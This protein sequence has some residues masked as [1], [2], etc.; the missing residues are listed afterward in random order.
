MKKFL[1]IVMWGFIIGGLLSGM[2]HAQSSAYTTIKKD[3]TDEL[4]MCLVYYAHKEYHLGVM[5]KEKT[6]TYMMDTC[7]GIHFAQVRTFAPTVDVALDMMHEEEVERAY[8]EL[9]EGA[10]NFVIRDATKQYK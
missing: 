5:D 10:L 8:E 9:A 6:I 1:F 3:Y 2:V 4:C 7:Y